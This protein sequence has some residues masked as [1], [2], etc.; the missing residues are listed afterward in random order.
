MEFFVE[1][2]VYVISTKYVDKKRRQNNI[3]TKNVDKK[4]DKMANA[5]LSEISISEKLLQ[6]VHGTIGSISILQVQLTTLLPIIFAHNIA[7]RN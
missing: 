6:V 7:F 5:T 3:S 4:L 1:F 2:F